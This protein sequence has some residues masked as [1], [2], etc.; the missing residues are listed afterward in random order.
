MNI[1][2]L[3]ITKLRTVT[4]FVQISLRGYTHAHLKGQVQ[5]YL[6]KITHIDH[7]MHNLRFYAQQHYKFV[8]SD[9]HCGDTIGLFAATH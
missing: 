1:T 8:F 2:F 7:L 6:L 4:K 9:S 3:C 5:Q